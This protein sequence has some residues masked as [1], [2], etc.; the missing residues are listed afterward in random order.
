MRER[1]GEVECGFLMCWPLFFCLPLKCWYSSEFF[2]R[3]PPLPALPTAGVTSPTQWLLWEDSQACVFSLRTTYSTTCCWST[4]EGPRAT[5]Y[6]SPTWISPF[7]L[8]LTCNNDQPLTG[9][10]PSFLSTWDWWKFPKHKFSLE[11]FLFTPFW[12]DAGLSGHHLP[13]QPSFLLS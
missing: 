13:L 6:S 10:L 3:S 5:S 4:C 9:L 2:T 1:K 11:I 8:S 7:L 12:Q